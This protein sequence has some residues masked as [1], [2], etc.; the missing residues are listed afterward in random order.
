[1]PPILIQ[2]IGVNGTYYCINGEPYRA[3]FG[4]TNFRAAT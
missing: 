3:D 2:V 1:M 4:L